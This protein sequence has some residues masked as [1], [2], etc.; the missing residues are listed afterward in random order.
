MR[1]TPAITESGATSPDV[2]E[3]HSA[4]V[5][6]VGD[7]AY[8]AKKPVDLGFLDF[9]T[10]E[11]RREACEREL[12]LNRRLAPDVYLGV[13]DVVDPEADGPCEHLLVMR[14][15]PAERRLTKLLSDGEDV[16]D[17]L[18]AIARDVG[19]FHRE[20]AA[21]DQ[22]EAYA[23]AGAVWSNWEDNVGTLR[24]FPEVIDEEARERVASRA[25]RY[26]DGRGPLLD[27]RIA[28][29]RVR[30]GH[31][32]LL[33]DDVFCLDDGPRILDCL[34]F[35]P[36]YR[37]GDVLLDAA[38]L[39]MDLERLGRADLAGA[40]LS[41][42]QEA[43]GDEHPASLAHHYLA[44]RAHVRA[45]VAC[46]RAEQGL[47]RAADTARAL[48]DLAD[49]HLDAGRVR[50]VLVGGAPGTGKSTLARGLARETGWTLLRSDEV[51]KE[52]AGVGH[53]DD[54]SA[55]P[56]EGL[57]R[58][59]AT[60]ATYRE[61]ADRAA[62]RLARG[63]SVVLDAT[64][65]S[66][67]HREQAARVARETSSDLVA[68]RC[69]APLEVAEQRIAARR[70]DA[71]DATADIARRLAAEADPWPEAVGI[72]TTPEPDRVVARAREHV[73]PVEVR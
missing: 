64:W 45:K 53:L 12:A 29:G 23:S 47:A 9:S 42:W 52:L 30:D 60:A 55:A 48:H 7:R 43:V 56:G 40:F 22:P 32:D 37:C 63:E 3:T 54:A 50:L 28:R 6:F 14:R 39:A 18:R 41:W 1:L 19:R 71:S 33:A 51:R 67:A 69:E 35:S 66:A 34:D 49:R 58:E 57:Y 68:L 38:F 72:D 70:S 8:K 24:R 59:E 36:R 16:T 27:E 44:Y 5:F 25:R 2:A 4:T 65:S 31:G 26:L 73:G 17:H 15:M 21:V 13:V 20:A 11:A 62:E 61:L 10:R 46:L